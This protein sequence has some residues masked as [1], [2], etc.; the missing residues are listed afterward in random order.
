MLKV[1]YI[2]KYKKNIYLCRVFEIKGLI[3]FG[4]SSGRTKL[5]ATASTM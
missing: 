3:H 1:S 2:S 5:L 4:I